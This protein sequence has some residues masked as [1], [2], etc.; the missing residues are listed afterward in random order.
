MDELSLGEESDA[1]PMHIDMLVDIRDGSQSCPI[2]NRR[3]ARYKIHDC[4]LK[5]LAKWK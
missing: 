5:R 3:D 4:I 1:E 2:I